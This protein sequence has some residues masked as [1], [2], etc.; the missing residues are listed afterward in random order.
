V[1]CRAA[2]IEPPATGRI[3]RIV[4]SALH[5]AE[6]TLAARITGRPPAD[7]AHRLRAL[8]A[9][10]VLDDDTG[11]ESV[12]ALIKRY[13]ATRA[14]SR[15]S[16]GPATQG[17]LGDRAAGRSLRRRR[18][19]VL[20]GWRARAMVE[21][22]SHLRDH[23]EPL[24][25]T[26]FAALLHSR[27]REITDTL[28]E[29]L[30][31][32]VHRI[33]ARADR[34]VT[35]E[36]INTFKPVTGK[37][38][39]LFAIAEASLNRPDDA[40]REVVYPAVSG[41]ER[42]LREL[43]HEFKTKGPVYRRTV[44]TMLDASYSNHYRRGLMELLMVLELRWNNAIHR[45]VLDALDLIRRHADSRLTYYRAVESVPSHKGCGTR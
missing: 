38:N 4:R 1:R 29:L 3:D 41:G 31:S 16:P 35:A 28:V 43:V 10:E 8:V 17:G 27:L 32:T 26:L 6:L 24:R 30:I 23:P 40:V 39:L 18:P 21:S 5:Q 33:G 34:K 11:E 14:S 9:V 37:E 20:A 2:R 45:P 7:V 19:R 12:L 42:T 25:L 36:L 44:Q 22:P 13:L 15:C